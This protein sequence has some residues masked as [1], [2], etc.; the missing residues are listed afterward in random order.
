VHLVTQ[1]DA[2]IWRGVVDAV[3]D[4]QQTTLLGDEQPPVGR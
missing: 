2:D 1:V 3:E 4:L